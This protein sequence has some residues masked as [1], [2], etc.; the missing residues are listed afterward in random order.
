MINSPNKTPPITH[1]L[2]KKCK[3]YKHRKHFVPRGSKKLRYDY[4][5]TECR[6][7]GLSIHDHHTMQKRIDTGL[8]TPERYE[9]LREMYAKRRKIKRDNAR[10]KERLN[11]IKESWKPIYEKIEFAQKIMDDLLLLSQEEEDWNEEVRMLLK[12]A[13]RTVNEL[14]ETGPKPDRCVFWYECDRLITVQFRELLERHPRGR[15]NAPLSMV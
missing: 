7:D 5:C 14:E 11:N 4:L 10:E 3:Q 13:A 1:K 15:Y 6:K 9:Q 8:F 12:T 2:C